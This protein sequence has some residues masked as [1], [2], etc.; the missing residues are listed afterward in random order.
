[1]IG[2]GSCSAFDSK[3]G[4]CAD[5]VLQVV[6]ADI[7]MHTATPHRAKPSQLDRMQPLLQTKPQKLA[8]KMTASPPLPCSMFTGMT[9]QLWPLAQKPQSIMLLCAQA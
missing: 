2:H 3:C 6:V 4:V 9:S 5:A 8:F 7:T 1:M